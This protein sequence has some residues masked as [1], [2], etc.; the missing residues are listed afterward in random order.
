MERM[1]NYTKVNILRL[2]QFNDKNRN[3]Q[4]FPIDWLNS[5]ELHWL[6][7]FCYANK[8]VFV[9]TKIRG[10]CCRNKF[11][12]LLRQWPLEKLGNKLFHQML[13]STVNWT[14]FVQVVVLMIL[15]VA[16]AEEIT[17]SRCRLVWAF[18]F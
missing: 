5:S 16:T 8:K 2:Y 12:C 11:F 7:Q 4:I 14:I 15:L 1:K 13:C 6:K 17:G 10:R 9:Y 3:Q 18:N